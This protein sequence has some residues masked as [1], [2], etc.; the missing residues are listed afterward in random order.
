[1]ILIFTALKYHAMHQQIIDFSSTESQTLHLKIGR[2]NQ[3][4]VDENQLLQELV[5][6]RYD[7]CRLK[8]PSEDEY[9]S[10]RL[11]QIGVPFFFSGSIRRYKTP[12]SSDHSTELLHPDMEFVD[13]DGSQEDLL[14]SMI[15]ATW[16][17][18]PIGYYRTPIIKHL[19]S[20]KI[21]LQSVFNF[22]KVQNNPNNNPNNRMM[23]MRHNREFVGFFALNIVD[24][25]LESHIGGIRKEF[26]HSGYF[27]DMLAFIKN[28]C[29]EKG[30]SHF[31]FGARNENAQ[32]Q[33]IFHHAGFVP[34]GSENVFH[35]TPMLSVGSSLLGE[36]FKEQ[37]IKAKKLDELYSFKARQAT[38][39][40]LAIKEHMAI[41]GNTLAGEHILSQKTFILSPENQ[42]YILELQ[43]E[44]SQTT[45]LRWVEIN[46]KN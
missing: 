17:N 18:Y 26:Q 27:Y 39:E 3:T 25:H 29:L 31:V 21:E 43:D 14:Y 42:L 28:H 23:F 13:Y 16:G 34:I 24:G 1:M 7:I 36:N 41:L 11:N 37:S 20:K 40:L 46:K 32:V 44:E 15:E 2:C 35:L 4:Q 10:D 12:I 30:L 6:N 5:K 8:V 45:A 19:V 22:Y 33:R 9:I 38:G